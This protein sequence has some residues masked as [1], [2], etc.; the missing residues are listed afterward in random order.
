MLWWGV[1]GTFFRVLSFGTGVGVVPVPLQNHKTL[2][3]PSN[4]LDVLY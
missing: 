4:Y 3:D 2:I 1:W